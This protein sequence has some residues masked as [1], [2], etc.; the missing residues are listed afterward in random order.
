MDATRFLRRPYAARDIC[1][2]DDEHEPLDLKYEVYKHIYLP[3]P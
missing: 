3:E 1:T 2:V